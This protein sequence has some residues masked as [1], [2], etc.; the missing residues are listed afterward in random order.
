MSLRSA[1]LA[2]AI[3]VAAAIAV[4]IDNF[5]RPLANPDEG[6][7][8]EIAREMAASGDWVTPRLNGIKYFEKPPLQYWATGAIFRLFGESEITARLYVGFAGLA[9]VLVAGYAASRLGSGEQGVAT[10]LA[11]VSSPYFMALGGIV[12][13][14]M[15]LTLW[16]TLTFCAIVIAES[17]ARDARERRLWLLVAWAAMALA[18]L[19]KGLVG[20]VFPAATLMA[21]ALMRRDLRALL[22]LEWTFGLV[23]FLAIAAPW[24]VAVSYANPE[25][26]EFFFIHEHFTRFLTTVHRRTEPWWYFFPILACGFLPWMFALPAAVAHA[27]RREKDA[28][29]LRPLTFALLWSTLIVAFF[30]A[31]G[32]KLPTY[33]LPVFPP[34]AIV[35]GR[36]LV[37][38]PSRRLSLLVAPSAL[39]A[40]ALAFLAWRAP[41][42]AHEAWTRSM[43]ED[44]QPWFYLAAAVLFVA[45]VIA[46]FALLRG[47]RWLGLVAIALGTV[48]AIDCVEDGYETF[49]PRQS[50]IAVAEKIRTVLTPDTRI[51]S[52]EHYDQT[53]PFYIGRTVI[54]VGYVDEFG[55][56]LAAEPGKDI[57]QVA[58]F[59]AAWLRPGEALAIMQPGTLRQFQA[60]GLPMQV[61][62]EDPR[63]ALVRKP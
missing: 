4:A 63:R 20:V 2:L 28:T 33:I 43:Y 37:E 51:Y 12:T 17:A 8:S 25:F 45:S 13:L 59:P 40:V 36:Y 35:L 42:S 52:V 38:V 58:D 62:H 19:S 55:P 11:L 48:G 27:W 16:T 61:L 24:F 57:A 53:V 3:L 26:P 15:G 32:S 56:G 39:V 14:D 60:Q 31:S 30:S 41:G 7:Y 47:R 46:S 50:G 18:L 21:Y 5:E 10:I 44:A 54:L 49:S 1:W 29:G 23:I 6:R 9:T 34:L 22:P